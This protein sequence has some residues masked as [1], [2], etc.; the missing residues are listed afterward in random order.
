METAFTLLGRLVT[1]WTTPTEFVT[2]MV[3]FTVAAMLALQYWPRS[4]GLRVQSGL[5][6]L[7]PAPLGIVLAIGLLAIVILGPTG[8]APFIYFQF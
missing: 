5:S 7:R 4:L 2:P 3:V 1:G 8:V 6:H